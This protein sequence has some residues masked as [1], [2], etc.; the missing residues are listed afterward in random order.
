MTNSVVGDRIKQARTKAGLTQV[1]L[2]EAVHAH[3]FTVSKWERGD[4]SPGKPSDYLAIAKACGVSINWLRD[5]KGTIEDPYVAPANEDRR[6]REQ[7]ITA[8][9][10]QAMKVGQIQSGKT[11]SYQWVAALAAKLLRLDP[12]LQEDRLARILELGSAMAERGGQID[13]EMCITLLRMVA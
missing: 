6:L 11:N 13:D 1:Q 12:S 8:P 2:G 3:K 4:T 5:G 9:H 10:G 7:R